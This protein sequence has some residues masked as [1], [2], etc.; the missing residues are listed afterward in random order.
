LNNYSTTE[1]F[2]EREDNIDPVISVPDFFHATKPPFIKGSQ[3]STWNET[4]I[5]YDDGIY[6]GSDF[7][8]GSSHTTSY[9]AAY[10]VTSYTGGWG[11]NNGGYWNTADIDNALQTAGD[12][13]NL[14]LR[15]TFGVLWDADEFPGWIHMRW[16]YY[17]N[18]P[19]DIHKNI[20]R[21]RIT[22]DVWPDSY[23]GVLD[24]STHLR[25]WIFDN[26]GNG[27]YITLATNPVHL[28]HYSGTWLI[29]GGVIFDNVVNSSGYINSCQVQMHANEEWWLGG[30]NVW[31][32]VDQFRIYYDYYD[33]DIDFS[34]ELEYDGLGLTTINEFN[35]TIDLV[36]SVAG[37]YVYFYDFQTL[38]WVHKDTLSSNGAE[39]ITGTFSSN[40]DH[41]FDVHYN[42]R[43]R[44][45]LYDF[46]N[47]LGPP[48]YHLYIDQIK[49]DIWLPDVPVQLEAVNGILHIF[50]TWNESQDYG[51][52]LT[53]YNVYR[54]EV[55]DGIKALIGS[56][57]TNEFNDTSLIVGTLYYYTITA[58]CDIGESSNS[59]EVSGQAY[60][61]PFV[62]WITPL[63]GETVIFPYNASDEFAWWVWFNFEYNY[64]ELDDVKLEIGGIDFGSVWNKTSIRFYPYIDGPL[65]LILHGFNQSVELANDTIN[66]TFVRIIHEVRERLDFGTEIL[67]QQLYLILH[68]PHGDHSYST[69]EETT[70]LSFG[71]GFSV[72][73]G[74]STYIKIGDEDGLFGQGGAATTLKLNTTLESGFDFRYEVSDVTSITSNIESSNPDYIGPGNG[75]MYWGESWI[76]KWELNSTRKV[77]S[78]DTNTAIYENPQIYYGILR[79][80]ETIANDIM[81]PENWKAQNPVHNGFSDVLWL[82]YFNCPGG[83]VFKRK[84][85]VSDSIARHTSFS[86]YFSSETIVKM[87]M[88]EFGLEIEM[89]FQ[90]YAESSLDHTI[91]TSYTIHDD[92]PTD[93]IV[94]GVGIDK[95]FG[96]YIFN[97]SE[98][99][100][101]TSLPLENNTYD[102]LPPILE[103]PD[104]VLDT[105]NDMIGPTTGD[106]PYV[107][108]EIFEEDEMQD[109]IINYTLDN[110]LNWDII[111]LQEQ[112]A[113]LGTWAA[114][115]P[116]QPINTTV[117][118]YIM[119]WDETGGKSIRMNTTGFPFS[120][121]VLPKPTSD[122]TAVPGYS[123]EFLIPVTIV[124]I[125]AI[126]MIYYRKRKKFKK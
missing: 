5:R 67:G 10:I 113:N 7:V 123:A 48:E 76:Y 23:P 58:V 18:P 105:D 91:E 25:L 106:T 12:Y 88:L 102:Y 21:I 126:T 86:L 74:L 9:Y 65:T 90:S 35:Y 79:D 19:A 29:S 28:Q 93:F 34:Y 69:F 3:V 92:E 31:I 32:N 75:D 104:I 80:V 63:D 37:V 54:G 17:P 53:H 52:P 64:Q 56:P 14:F 120:Y 6:D 41:F 22:Y 16:G 59:S 117:K 115:I 73:L 118:W 8:S 99:F 27:Q 50:L 68:D 108:V 116:A 72:S 13:N 43:I 87:P 55:Q 124:S 70:T 40:A 103:F 78:N 61:Q 77:Y 1:D 84:H 97:S 47:S 125:I 36:D 46:F 111:H 85:L 20:Y 121:T 71:V 26:N 4:N 24:L 83:E 112:V 38:Q 42:M 15:A 114:N 96:T 81:A 107:T 122:L 45:A 94:Q 110:G 33:Y 57:T 89:G 100:C 119:A 39:T 11:T 82:G 2:K 98:F 101:E 49:I 62:E 30:T 60:D 109:A 44:F 95:K 51:M 66:L